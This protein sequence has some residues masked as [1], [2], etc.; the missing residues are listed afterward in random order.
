MRGHALLLLLTDLQAVA[1]KHRRQQS[2][3]VGHLLQRRSC[4]FSQ[5]LI[6]KNIPACCWFFGSLQWNSMPDREARCLCL[7]GC[8]HPAKTDHARAFTSSRH[9]SNYYL[10][11]NERACIRLTGICSFKEAARPMSDTICRKVVTVQC[12]RARLRRHGMHFILRDAKLSTPRL[13]LVVGFGCVPRGILS[14]Q[15]GV[16]RF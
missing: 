5:L 6:S 14:R 1:S 8:A 7:T 13:A 11:R 10:S 9:W 15:N 4:C 16:A 3:L 12:C 2:L